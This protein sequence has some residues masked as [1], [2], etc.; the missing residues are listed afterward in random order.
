[1]GFRR[2]GAGPRR[3]DRERP[4]GPHL[5]RLGAER[6]RGALSPLRPSTARRAARAD[7]NREGSRRHA[8]SLRAPARL[9]HTVELENAI[10]GNS[11]TLSLR[12]KVY[13]SSGSN[14]GGRP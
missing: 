9:A 13:P 3:P 12:F 6:P 4:R 1:G 14:N 8:V 7:G 2:E 10:P 11:L 5:R